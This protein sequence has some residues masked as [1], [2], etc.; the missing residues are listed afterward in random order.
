MTIFVSGSEG[1]RGGFVFG[2][3]VDDKHWQGGGES[4]Q[5]LF[6]CQCI[7]RMEMIGEPRIL[8]LKGR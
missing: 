2:E 7:Q 6:R 4:C 3:G 8:V 5:Q 1:G